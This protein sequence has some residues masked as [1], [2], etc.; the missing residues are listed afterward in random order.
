M[1]AFARRAASVSR[2][3]AAR[4][5]ASLAHFVAGEGHDVVG[6]LIGRRVA[7]Q[8]A[9]RPLGEIERRRDNRRARNSVRP[10]RV[11]PGL[12]RRAHRALRPARARQ[13]RCRARG[14][15]ACLQ[16]AIASS[17]PARPSRGDQRARQVD[18]QQ[19]LVRREFQRA[20]V[21]GDRLLRRGRSQTGSGPSVPGSTGLLRLLGDQ[22]VEFARAPGR[23][24]RRDNRRRRARS[25][26]A[27]RCR[28]SG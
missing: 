27:A 17:A 10:R 28:S 20:A 12:P 26:R 22:H 19:R 13:R 5:A 6:A 3:G 16:Q 15:T 1:A 21:I 24:R 23:A 11:R 25:A 18:L 8:R 14:A 7:R 4:C 9:A 2:G